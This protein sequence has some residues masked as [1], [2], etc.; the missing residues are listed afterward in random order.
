M[1]CGSC[2][3]QIKEGGK[4]CPNCGWNVPI[5]SVISPKLSNVTPS[6]VKSVL[7]QVLFVLIML[8]MLVLFIL[9]PP[10]LGI[11]FYYLFDV[12]MPSVLSAV[13]AILG[14]IVLYVLCI[15]AFRVLYDKAFNTFFKD[16]VD[17]A[18]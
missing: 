14:T 6:D 2:G 4:F 16:K 8:P 3:S 15:K 17:G 5:T 13:L 7:I 1:F 9:V 11:V 12:F 18:S 10:V